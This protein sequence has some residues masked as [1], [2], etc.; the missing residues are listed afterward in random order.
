M[1]SK[2][3]GPIRLLDVAFQ[4]LRRDCF[5]ERLSQH[6][7]EFGFRRLVVVVQLPYGIQDMLDPLRSAGYIYVA[8]H[9]VPRINNTHQLIPQ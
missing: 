5:P 3:F 6:Y 7:T 2:D 9:G 1:F 4:A 8:A